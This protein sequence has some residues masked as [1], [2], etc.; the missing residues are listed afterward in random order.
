MSS[1][2]VTR[3]N[4]IQATQKNSCK[5]PTSALVKLVRQRVRRNYERSARYMAA[6]FR[7]WIWGWILRFRDVSVQKTVNSKANGHDSVE[8]VD[9]L[10]ATSA[11]RSK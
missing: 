9:V 1:S 6:G 10:V 2:T 11:Q 8:T 3:Y 4:R 7:S 5:Q